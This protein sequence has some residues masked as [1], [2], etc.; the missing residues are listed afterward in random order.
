[1]KKYL[2]SALAFLL[3][4]VALTACGN[5]SDDP[6]GFITAPAVTEESVNPTP[7]MTIPP[8]EL[9]TTHP[10]HSTEPTDP[11]VLPDMTLPS[12]SVTA[13]DAAQ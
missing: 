8:A 4:A 2:A 5:V 12:E 9:P 6:H 3:I 13:G 7:T 11:A 10:T 1:M